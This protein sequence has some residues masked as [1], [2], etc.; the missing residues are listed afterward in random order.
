[1]TLS[2]TKSLIIGVLRGWFLN[3]K[4]LDKF[5]DDNGT[6]LY[7]GKD[8]SGSSNITSAELAKAISD[9]ITELNTAAE[10]EEE[11]PVTP[12]LRTFTVGAYAAPTPTEAD[13]VTNNNMI[14]SVSVNENVITVTADVANLISFASSNP[15]QGTHK[16][17]AIGIDTGITPIT[18]VSYNGY[19]LELQDVSDAEATGCN[20]KSFILYIKADEVISTP[21]QFTLSADGY[22]SRTMT[23]TVAQS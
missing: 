18:N 10:E 8:I 4:V 7:D 22:E 1:M 13:G 20:E 3:K 9:T 17:L 23:I 21:N 16:W 12:E 11:Q 15:S 5:S 2:Q 19:P 14:S 6:L